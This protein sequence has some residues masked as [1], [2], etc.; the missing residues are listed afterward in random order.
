MQLTA[1]TQNMPF[2]SPLSTFIHLTSDF[3]ERRQTVLC[4]KPMK[5]QMAERFLCLHSQQLD[6]LR[7]HVTE[8]HMENTQGDYFA[9]WVEVEQFEGAQSVKEV[10]DALL[11]SAANFEIAGAN[12]LGHI[13]VRDDVD[14]IDGGVWN[15]RLVFKGANG[16]Q[17]ESNCVTFTQFQGD[18]V[19]SGCEAPGVGLFVTDFVD[20]DDLYPYE[21]SH[22]VRRDVSIVCMLTPH[23]QLTAQR[24]SEP[25]A[26]AMRTT[27]EFVVVLQHIVFEKIHRSDLPIDQPALRALRQGTKGWAEVVVDGMHERLAATRARA[28][29][30]QRLL[31]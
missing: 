23:W 7:P 5:L 13:I 31:M 14:T 30:A 1:H 26:A 16:T 27:R 25:R 17:C 9:T 4:M 19:F 24:S 8:S 20:K 22:N 6:L 2:E 15:S 12:T 11:Y 28:D 29:A 21:P 10:F 3:H 18:H